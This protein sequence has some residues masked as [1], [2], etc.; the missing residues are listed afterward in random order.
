MLVKKVAVRRDVSLRSAKVSSLV[1][2]Q[3]VDCVE[4]REEGGR[5]NSVSLWQRSRRR[6]VH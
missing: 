5:L 3:V 6:L 1:Q 4:Q 2:D